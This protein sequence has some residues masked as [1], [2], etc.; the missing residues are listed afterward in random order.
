MTPPTLS[1]PDSAASDLVADLVEESEQIQ[2]LAHAL[3]LPTCAPDGTRL[4]SRHLLATLVHL[5]TATATAAALV[6]LTDTPALAHLRPLSSITSALSG[7]LAANAAMVDTLHH[8]AI[9][10][11]AAEAAGLLRTSRAQAATLLT[12]ASAHLGAAAAQL[13]ATSP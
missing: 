6:D 7:L 2:A 8:F 10:P 5:A 4:L 1:P 3:G 13:R 11:A 12:S 9:E